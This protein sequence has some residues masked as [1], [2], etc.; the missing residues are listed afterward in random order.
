MG[1]A[2]KLM[3]LDAEIFRLQAELVKKPH[4]EE[5]RK[6]EELLKARQELLVRLEREQRERV[7]NGNYKGGA[8][9]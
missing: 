6:L 7:E 2:T 3:D 1:T 5:T 8:D 9:E 4:A